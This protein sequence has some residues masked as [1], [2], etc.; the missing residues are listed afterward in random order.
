LEIKKI[1]MKLLI[2]L[3]II[4]FIGV[5]SP[6]HAQ[7]VGSYEATHIISFIAKT[8]DM[9]EVQLSWE[10]FQE[11]DNSFIRIERSKNGINFRTVSNINDDETTKLGTHHYLDTQPGI[12][13][14]YYQLKYV[15]MDGNNS[16][17]PLIDILTT[18]TPYSK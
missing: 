18:Y 13:I 4:S 15:D 17:T 14:N 2:I 12:G 5:F 8:S 11:L 7:V 1:G 9:G 10:L 3:F 6:M 16:Y